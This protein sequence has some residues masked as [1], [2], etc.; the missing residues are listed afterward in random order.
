MIAHT[1]TNV[2]KCALEVAGRDANPLKCF[3]FYKVTEFK[4]KKNKAMDSQRDP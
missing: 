4:I 3:K 2:R 1:I